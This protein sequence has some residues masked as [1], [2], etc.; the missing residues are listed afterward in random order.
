MATNYQTLGMELRPR[1]MY[2]TNLTTTTGGAPSPSGTTP[3]PIGTGRAS[4]TGTE[5]TDRGGDPDQEYTGDL[6][7]TQIDKL[8]SAPV[9]QSAKSYPDGIKGWIQEK[10]DY[11]LQP[12]VSYNQV[13]G[14]YR[15]VGPGGGIGGIAAM[16]GLPVA[17]MGE[18]NRLNMTDIAAKAYAGEKGYAVGLFNGQMIGTSPG[19]LGSTLSGNVPLNLSASQRQQLTDNLLGLENRSGA[20][21]P[22]IQAAYEDGTLQR[23]FTSM[24]TTGMSPE[25]YYDFSPN[26]GPYASVPSASISGTPIRSFVDTGSQSGTSSSPF[27][28]SADNNYGL[29]PDRSAVMSKSGPVTS[30]RD[31]SI[32]TSRNFSYNDDNNND[33]GSSS[34]GV[35]DPG[36]TRGD[37]GT[38][39]AGGARY[40]GRIGY[41]PGGEVTSADDALAEALRDDVGDYAADDTTTDLSDMGGF[42]YG[43]DDDRYKADVAKSIQSRISNIVQ[44]QPMTPDERYAANA[45]AMKNPDMYSTE[46]ISVGPTKSKSES[47]GFGA[48]V[49]DALSDVISAGMQ[50][51]VLGTLGLTPFREGGSV[52]QGFINKDPDT[53]SD[54]QSIADNRY[55]TVKAGSFVMNQPAN[56]KNEKK[57][58]KIVA[59]ASKRAKMKKGG[60]TSMI[61]V[62]LSDGERL[63]EP[64]VVAV[65]EK[66]HGKG[67]LDKLNDEGKPEVKRRQAMYG[68]KIGLSEGGTAYID[69][70]IDVTDVGDDIPM[71]DFLPVSD[72]LKA[73][74][75]K[76]GNKKPQRSQIK[77]FI[78]SLSPEEKLTVLFLTETK[79]STDSIEGMEAIGEVVNNRINSDYYD[80]ANIKTLDDALLKQTRR[81]AFQFSGLEPT[82]FF[83]RAKE[84]KKGVA[85]TGLAR[86]FAAA[87]NVLS[88]EREGANRLDPNTLFYTRTDAPSQ[89]MRESKDLEFSTEL[90]EHEFYRTFASPEFP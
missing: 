24:Q 7:V 46:G 87:Q 75:A 53:V 3:F 62:A 73:K 33:G 37:Y 65:I 54:K 50:F 79:S 85:D 64:E 16:A 32:V 5:T 88:P 28:P 9:N 69:Q 40:G 22:N 66:K 52:T 18:L 82:T 23:D 17:Y 45:E 15:A 59:D 12:E 25:Q 86:A 74:I 30:G 20:Y 11:A 51:G 36:D 60:K 68:D 89:W 38:E 70:G 1:P 29:A 27:V 2:G 35:S 44:S 10:I 58:D 39:D 31:Q 14:T 4:A 34:S 26:I 77:A 80:F 48:S 81:G 55:T 42:G 49:G 71:E 83:N 78:K 41:A 72:E 90:G 19:F 21:D 8:T 47:K 84:V 13:T 76:F 6:S 67:F 56:E 43:G 61:K 63:I 57:L